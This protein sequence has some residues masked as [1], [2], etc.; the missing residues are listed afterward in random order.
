LYECIGHHYLAT[1][2]LSECEFTDETQETFR[3]LY[4]ETGN[5]AVT[6]IRLPSNEEE[7]KVLGFC[8]LRKSLACLEDSS[9]HARLNRELRGKAGLQSSLQSMKDRILA[10]FERKEIQSQE[11]L[12][13]YLDPPKIIGMS[14][15]WYQIQSI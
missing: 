13:H 2:L 1:L 15:L 12:E 3:Y 14:G 9:R 7:M 5:A 11:E 4:S 8:H 6:D 10:T